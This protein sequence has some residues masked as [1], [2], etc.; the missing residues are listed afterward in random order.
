MGDMYSGVE[1]Q[2]SRHGEEEKASAVSPDDT[3]ALFHQWLHLSRTSAAEFARL[4]CGIAR[5][6]GW[7]REELDSCQAWVTGGSRGEPIPRNIVNTVLEQITAASRELAVLNRRLTQLNQVGA[8]LVAATLR[9]PVRAEAPGTAAI[10]AQRSRSV[11]PPAREVAAAP[12]LTPRE[13]EILDL[14]G[15]GHSNRQIA[16]RLGVA[17]RTVKNHLSSLFVKLGATDRTTAVLSAL[18]HG[19]ITVTPGCSR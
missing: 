11:P 2:S 13:R 10:P 12:A 18:R 19:L 17:E 3:S 5:D 15:T 16:R 14:L 6:R 1:C 4:L 7:P 9:E 8:R